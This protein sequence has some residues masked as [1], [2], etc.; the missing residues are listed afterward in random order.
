[1][2]KKFLNS[3]QITKG[4]FFCEKIVQHN[5]KVKTSKKDGDSGPLVAH[6]YQI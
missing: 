4:A 2:E 3:K 5:L 1:M 6:Q